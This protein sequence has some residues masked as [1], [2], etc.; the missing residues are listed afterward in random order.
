MKVHPGDHMYAAISQSS[1]GIWKITIKDLT[2]HESYSRTTSYAST[3]GTAEWIEETPLV[4]GSNAG[5]APL[6]NLSKARFDHATANGHKVKLK[7]SQEIKLTSASGK[8]VGV[9]SAPD[10]DRDGFNACAW[11]K[12]CRPPRKS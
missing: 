6:P 2:R 5:F 4:I 12:S 1:P 8:V 11:V 10:P 3:E 7:A 9:P